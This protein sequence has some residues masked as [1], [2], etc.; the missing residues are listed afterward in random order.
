M[1]HNEA[2]NTQCLECGK[3]GLV[4]TTIDHTATMRYEGTNYQ[5]RVP[6]L[7]AYVCPGCKAVEFQDGA[8]RQLGD[9]FCAVLG[10][11]TPAHLRHCRE[12]LKVTQ[13]E[14][15]DVL[16]IAAESISR[17]ESGVV[18]QSRAYDRFLRTYFYVPEAREY[19][20][21]PQLLDEDISQL[22]LF[23]QP[24]RVEVETTEQETVM[25]SEAGNGE[26]NYALAA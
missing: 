19:L 9:A 17:W 6:E 14:L 15:A 26:R 18:V 24:P 20:L 25:E 10:L 11:M 16:G 21:A 7:M 12:A 2:H 13:R 1:A 8:R 4:E 23:C 22:D 3:H 5:V